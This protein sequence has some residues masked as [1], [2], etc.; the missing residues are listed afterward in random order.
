ME[1]H[2]DSAPEPPRID[3]VEF[4]DGPWAGEHEVRSDLPATIA[5]PGGT[6]RQ[7]VRCADDGAMRYV[8]QG[9]ELTSAR[10]SDEEA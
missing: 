5:A 9:P 2:R 7:S 3:E 4:I 8:W 6:Y 10:G 1:A